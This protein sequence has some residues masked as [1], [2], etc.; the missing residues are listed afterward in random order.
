MSNDGHHKFRKQTSHHSPHCTALWL[1]GEA[2]C[3]LSERQKKME[4]QNFFRY[5]IEMF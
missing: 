3:K 2:S 1:G 5:L 4:A